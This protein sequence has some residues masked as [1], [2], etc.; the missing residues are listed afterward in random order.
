MVTNKV[1]EPA[2]CAEVR[3]FI[4]FWTGSVRLQK[5]FESEKEILKRRRDKEKVTE[6]LGPKVNKGVESIHAM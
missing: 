2:S 3:T 5:C 4:V 6:N 1:F